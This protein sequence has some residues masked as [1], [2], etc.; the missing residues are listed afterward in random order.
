M[1]KETFKYFHDLLVMV[2]DSLGLMTLN[3]YPI[4]ETSPS[5]QLRM[6]MEYKGNEV[7]WDFDE[8]DFN[9]P[10]EDLARRVCTEVKNYY[11]ERHP[12]TT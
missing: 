1:K 2:G 12:E 4:L 6:T 11:D 5:G 7:K 3:R 10:L 9:R 8:F